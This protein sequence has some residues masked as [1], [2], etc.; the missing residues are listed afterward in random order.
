MNDWAMN[1]W[2]GLVGS[3]F[4]DDD[5]EKCLSPPPSGE[6]IA[7]APSPSDDHLWVFDGGAVWDLGPAEDDVDADGIADSLVR[8]T[9]EHATVYTATDADGRVD[10]ITEVDTGGYHCVS[11]LDP[12]SGTWRATTFG[13]LE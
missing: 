9:A 12:D 2:A 1:D 11:A 13:R 6:S 10:R 3:G 7:A 8:G 4:V 5:G